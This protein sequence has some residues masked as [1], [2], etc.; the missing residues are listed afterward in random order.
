MVHA[1]VTEPS[2]AQSQPVHVT[3]LLPS[4]HKVGM[5]VLRQW[6]GATV[7]K[8]SVY[9]CVLMCLLKDTYV[10]MCVHVYVFV[11]VHMCSICVCIYGMWAYVS[12]HSVCVM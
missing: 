1:N 12:V 11:G 9:V 5:V 3:M 6:A 2:S 10:F 8:L 7:L 4:T